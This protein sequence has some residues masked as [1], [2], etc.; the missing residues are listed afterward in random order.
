MKGKLSVKQSVMRRTIMVKVARLQQQA[1]PD[2]NDERAVSNSGPF[3]DDLNHRN[4]ICGKQKMEG[5]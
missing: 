4:L 1:S 2:V 5:G 3:K